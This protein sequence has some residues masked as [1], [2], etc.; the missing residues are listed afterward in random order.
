MKRLIVS[1]AVFAASVAALPSF[2]R[3]QVGLSS[4]LSDWVDISRGLGDEQEDECGGM[5]GLATHEMAVRA[6]YAAW[7]DYMTE[8]SA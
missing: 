1:A 3:A 5:R 4:H 7:R 6:Q 2:A 8:P